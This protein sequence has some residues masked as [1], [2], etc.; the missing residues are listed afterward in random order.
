MNRCARKGYLV[1]ASG[2]IPDDP[3]DL[4]V[5]LL[6]V[7]GCSNLTCMR[8][9]EKVT[10]QVTGGLRE[11]R[12]GC[13]NWLET[14]E[15]PLFD[16]D[17]DPASDPTMPW[18]CAGHP[19][20]TLPRTVDGVDLPDDTALRD[21][22]ERVLRGWHPPGA[23]ENDEVRV[24]W[25]R[26][27]YVRL[28]RPVALLD[29]ALSCVTDPAVE[30]RGR[31][32]VFFKTASE[33]TALA[34][35]VKVLDDRALFAG[36]EDPIT[37]ISNETLEDSL[38][39][40]LAPLARTDGGVRNLVR[41][42]ATTPGRG[43][44]A[45]Y[46]VLATV[47]TDWLVAN[48]EAVARANRDRAD[49]LIASF[50]AV[51][52]GATIK[53]ARER[54]RAAVADRVPR[55]R[56]TAEMLFAASLVPCPTCAGPT[57][58]LEISVGP[59]AWVFSGKCPGCGTVRSFQFTVEGNPRTNAYERLELGDARPSAVIDPALFLAELERLAP[60]LR[61]DPTSLSGTAWTTN[62]EN[63]ER[64]Y[65]CAVELAKYLPPGG[66]NVPGV[67]H[68]RAWIEGERDRAVTRLDRITADAPRIWALESGG[69]LDA[70]DE[71]RGL[72]VQA[73]IRRRP[74]IDDLTRYLTSRNKTITRLWTD[75]RGVHAEVDVSGMTP[76]DLGDA[77]LG[78][79]LPV[80]ID[81]PDEPRRVTVHFGPSRR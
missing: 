65:T 56:T 63:A 68:D 24:A 62:K 64:A 4:G 35:L 48:V 5:E 69:V 50:A 27:M 66:G 41:R 13:S 76:D 75:V 60:L 32:L 49:D 12:C 78:I 39:R 57:A 74:S 71:L 59:E 10:H 11:Y 29:A 61:D 7:V 19:P 73:G 16:P 37:S 9:N 34:H 51:A 36:I 47:D 67:P 25:L 43:S 45:V 52:A 26:R 80:D 81:Q 20:I 79:T 58:K 72:L 23:R 6:P 1:D 77:L 3:T 44:R 22:A 46:D 17:P 18:E 38:W 55:A 8:C 2:V 15:H 30:T 21:I 14:S 42:A 40:D 54:A 31:A 33:P 70:V 28:A 53:A